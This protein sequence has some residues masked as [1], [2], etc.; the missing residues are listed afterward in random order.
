MNEKEPQELP[1]YTSE[2]IKSLYGLPWA[3]QSHPII[4]W[5]SIFM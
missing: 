4:I 3:H 5:F 2:H 1:E